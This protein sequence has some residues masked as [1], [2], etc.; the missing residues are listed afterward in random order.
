MSDVETRDLALVPGPVD[1]VVGA[2]PT[3]QVVLVEA[4][5]AQGLPGPQGPVGPPGPP[6]ALPPP[7][8]ADL[9]EAMMIRDQGAGPVW[10]ID[11]V[12]A[13]D[14]SGLGALA[15]LSS[16]NTAQITDGA[17]TSAKL[18]NGAV[19]G[20]QL[21]ANSVGASQI[22][23]G[24]VGTAELGPGIVTQANLAAGSVGTAQLIDANVT[25][26]KLAAGSV[27][28]AQLIDANVTAAK[29]AAGVAATNLGFVP[30]NPASNL[31]ELTNVVTARTNLGRRPGRG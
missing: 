20:A 18:A 21:A 4:S 28:T 7:V 27:G 13:A 12:A 19:G 16:V 3:Q 25:N 1:V 9:G 23:D 14:V 10:V 6:G 15:T 26:V 5:I 24:S 22:I 8:P 30:L 11:R 29:L 17:V 31:S 2:N